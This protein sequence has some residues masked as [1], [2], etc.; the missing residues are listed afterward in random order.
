M[1]AVTDDAQETLRL[2]KGEAGTGRAATATFFHPS[3]IGF[4]DLTGMIEGKQGKQEN[5]PDVL[6]STRINLER[7]RNQQGDRPKGEGASLPLNGDKDGHGTR[8]GSG[9]TPGH[10]NPGGVAASLHPSSTVASTC[11]E[12]VRFLSAPLHGVV[13]L[14]CTVPYRCINH[15]DLL[16]S[17]TRQI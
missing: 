9:R 2:K 4:A 10:T 17:T 13:L 3:Q 6:E 11:Y 8:V 7:F 1:T 5:R 14:Y 16:C 12:L 15:S